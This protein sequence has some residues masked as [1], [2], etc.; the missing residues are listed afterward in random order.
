MIPRS[1]I[2]IL[3]D[4]L[5]DVVKPGDDVMISG[6]FIQR[7]RPPFINTVRPEIEVAVLANNITVLN[8][9]DFNIKQEIN[10]QACSDFKKYW[11]DHET[12]M[13]EGKNKVLESI[14]PH[15]YDRYAEKLGLLLALIGG[16][17]KQ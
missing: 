1:I 10:Q 11:K 4:N 2:V 7:W 5:V 14:A 17:P 16:V 6:M 9:R 3:E 13:L 12:K 8:K 15:I